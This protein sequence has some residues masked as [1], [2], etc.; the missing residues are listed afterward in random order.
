MNEEDKIKEILA[1]LDNQLQIDAIRVV[2]QSNVKDK[3]QQ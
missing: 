3:E 2:E 1:S